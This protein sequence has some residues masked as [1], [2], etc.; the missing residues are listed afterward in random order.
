MDFEWGGQ[1]FPWVIFSHM[2]RDGGIGNSLFKHVGR[3]AQFFGSLGREPSRHFSHDHHD[4][5][6]NE[7]NGY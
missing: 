3:R 7:S 6:T 5:P 1:A 4:D 2:P